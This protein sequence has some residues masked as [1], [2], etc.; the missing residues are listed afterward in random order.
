MHLQIKYYLTKSFLSAVVGALLPLPLPYRLNTPTPQICA[1]KSGQQNKAAATGLHLVRPE[2]TG[3]ANE[4][5]HW[6]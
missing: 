3:K 2:I 5:G 6:C 4:E 1:L